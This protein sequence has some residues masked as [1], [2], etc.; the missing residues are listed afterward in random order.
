MAV[1]YSF[2]YT[3][4]AWRVQ[5][6]INMGVVEG[7]S[8]LNAQKWEEVKRNG[9]SAIQNWIDRQMNRKTAVVVLVG[10][11]TANRRW[12]KYEITKAWT[13]RRP[14]VGIRIHG[15]AD[16]TDHTDALG[17]NPFSRVTLKNGKTVAD[18][19]QLYTPRGV[20]SPA[21]YADIQANLKIW[22]AN[23]YKRD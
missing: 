22:V 10:A 20:R 17:A 15:L 13:E 4:D 5:Q 9:D 23:A 8:I 14:L 1:F 11:Q 21:V 6:I 2:H 19:V 12:V 16:R 3:R 7:Q 18:Y